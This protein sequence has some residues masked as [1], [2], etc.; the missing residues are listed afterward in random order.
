MIV[1][2]KMFV[3]DK[4]IVIGKM[5]TG[6]MAVAEDVSD[7]I[8]DSVADAVAEDVAVATCYFY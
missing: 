3:T 8:A 1:I 6:K 2:G 4:M 5:V 7:A